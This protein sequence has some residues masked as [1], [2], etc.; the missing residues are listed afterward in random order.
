[1]FSFA[2]MAPTQ[3]VSDDIEPFRTSEM[4][5]ASRDQLQAFVHA[6]NATTSSELSLRDQ[7]E[8]YWIDLEWAKSEGRPNSTVEAFALALLLNG[9]QSFLG[10]N[11]HPAALGFYAAPQHLFDHME[12]ADCSVSW[13]KIRLSVAIGKSELLLGLGPEADKTQRG[14][15]LG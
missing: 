3:R 10:R 1:M 5:G 9:L 15:S 7:D 2:A 13:N 8:N 11:R 12:L 4:A 6:T 14:R